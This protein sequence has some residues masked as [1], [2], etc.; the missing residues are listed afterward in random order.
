MH[1][2]SRARYSMKEINDTIRVDAI[3]SDETINRKKQIEK[4]T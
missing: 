1:S 3:N 2:N 4:G